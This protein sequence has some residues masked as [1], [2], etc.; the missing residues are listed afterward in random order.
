MLSSLGF[1]DWAANYRTGGVLGTGANVF[2][3][4]GW[5]GAWLAKDEYTTYHSDGKMPLHI[6]EHW[7]RWSIID[8]TALVGTMLIGFAGPGAIFIPIMWVRK[9]RRQAAK[10]V[11][12]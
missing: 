2:T 4:Y 7:I 5:P 3:T 11:G 6:D 8:V 12:M 1:L 10:R 9:K